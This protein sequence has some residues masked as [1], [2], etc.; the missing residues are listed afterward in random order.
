[1][2][3]EERPNCVLLL[4]CEYVYVVLSLIC[5]GFDFLHRALDILRV[6]KTSIKTIKAT[7]MTS[8]IIQRA[9]HVMSSPGDLK[10]GAVL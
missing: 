7:I 2:A 1:M 5:F 4:P 3:F 6:R 9:T 10:W 8:S